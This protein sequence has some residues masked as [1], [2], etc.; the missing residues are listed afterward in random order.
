MMLL[1]RGP[2]P[3]LLPSL[4]VAAGTEQGSSHTHTYTLDQLTTT[5]GCSSRYPAQAILHAPP[6]HFPTPP[7]TGNLQKRADLAV[8]VWWERD[9]AGH[10]KTRAAL[11]QRLQA[12]CRLARVP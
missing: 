3:A 5:P 8:G 4:T 2:R 1:Q 12:H 11:V 7:D 6:C 9:S 10:P